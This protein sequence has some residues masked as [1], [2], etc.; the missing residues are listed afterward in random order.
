MNISITKKFNFE[1]AHSLPNHDGKCRNLHGHSY[2]F[3]VT[4]GGSVVNNG[5]KEGMVMD[6]ADLKKV[7]NEEILLS[8]DHSYLNDIVPF[9]TTAENLALEIYNRL[10]NKNISVIKVK[11]WETSSAFVEVVG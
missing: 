11:L 3:E 7:V 2:V 8:W 5:P 9:V 1:A 10:K 6:F 4:V